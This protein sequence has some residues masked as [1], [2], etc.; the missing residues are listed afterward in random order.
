MILVLSY[1]IGSLIHP[2]PQTLRSSTENHGTAVSVS[3]L[4][5]PTWSDLFTGVLL[6]ETLY[7]DGGDFYGT[8][9]DG[10]AETYPCNSTYSLDLSTS[11]SPKDV[12]FNMIDKGDSPVFNRPNLWSVSDGQSFYSFNGD[13]SQA[14]DYR[15]TDPPSTPQ[16]W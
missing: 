11:W 3:C 12:R 6:V 7:I 2:R 14:G 5:S 10:L 15:T 13:V 16:L 1:R 8:G 4:V 9:E